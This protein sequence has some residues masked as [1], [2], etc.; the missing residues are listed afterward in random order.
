MALIRGGIRG[1]ENVQQ[2]LQDATAN[3]KLPTEMI[4][5]GP[6]SVGKKMDGIDT[7][8]D[9]LCERGAS[10]CG[11]CGSCIRA[12]K[13]QHEGLLVVQTEETN[14]KLE[15][16]QPI[17]DFVRLRLLGRARVIIINDAHKL[18]IQA[19]NRLLKTL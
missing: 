14:M 15:D 17:F 13:L 8:Q 19:A 18:N 4:F 12:S 16:I 3:G 10:A 11:E 1:H 6:E 7:A 5:R 9:L 2:A